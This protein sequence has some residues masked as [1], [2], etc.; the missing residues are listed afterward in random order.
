[1]LENTNRYYIYS[2]SQYLYNVFI[3]FLEMKVATESSTTI[4]TYS[5]PLCSQPNLNT[6]VKSLLFKSNLEIKKKILI[7]FFKESLKEHLSSIHNCTQDALNRCLALIGDSGK[8][9]I[10]C[11]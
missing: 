1:M 8:I 3:R 2:F 6:L 5:C 9:G 4:D 7:L 11:I 10:S